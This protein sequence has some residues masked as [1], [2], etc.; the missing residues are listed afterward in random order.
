M[1][2]LKYITIKLYVLIMPVT[3]FY[4]NNPLFDA[5]KNQDFSQCFAHVVSFSP[6]Y[7]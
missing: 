7:F 2:T 1:Y 6:A 4:G 3:L 5:K